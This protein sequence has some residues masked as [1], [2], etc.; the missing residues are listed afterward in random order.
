MKRF[1]ANIGSRNAALEQRPEVLK[2][3]RMD[4]A[5]HILNGVVNNL[6]R[7]VARQ[8]IVGEQGVGIESRASFYVL[9][10]FALQCVLL[11]IRYDCGANL[12][13]TFQDAHNCGL[14]LG[15]SPGNP[16]LAFA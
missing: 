16:A 1:H 2:S 12:P 4:A 11:A 5:I 8:T 15:S 13:A 9:A 7:V 10:D 6:V 14:V 3:V